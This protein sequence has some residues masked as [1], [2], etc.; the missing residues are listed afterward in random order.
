MT[1]YESAVAM[2]DFDQRPKNMLGIRKNIRKAPYT[3][4]SLL[5]MTCVEQNQ[6][7]KQREYSL[8][9]TDPKD[10]IYGLLG[11]ASDYDVLK[12][13]AERDAQRVIPNYAL[14]CAEIYTNFTMTMMIMGYPN[15][16]SLCQFPKT[17]SGLPSWVPDWSTPLKLQLQASMNIQ[18]PALSPLYFAC[19]AGTSSAARMQFF[20][21]DK[22]E[23]VCSTDGLILDKIAATRTTYSEITEKSKDAVAWVREW[24]QV[25]NNLSKQRLGAYEDDDERMLAVFR[26]TTADFCVDEEGRWARVSEKGLAAAS[27]VHWIG[28]DEEE[29][30]KSGFLKM[31]EQ[32]GL[33]P[34]VD[35]EAFGDVGGFR[36]IGDVG[37]RCRGRRPFVTEKGYLGLGP[38]AVNEGDKVGIFA[39]LQ[40]PFLLRPYG[41][42]YQLV[43]E[44]YVDGVTD[45]EAFEGEAVAEQILLY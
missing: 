34:R 39:G 14:S 5:R 22:K 9:A 23:T 38:M 36:Y 2:A 35:H 21:T 26:T 1:E 7:M 44:A 17:I 4:M 29:V 32:N 31:L 28:A 33:P 41:S 16:I 37:L 20:W 25:L 30:K 13:I 10:K 18:E 43:G 6:S 40:V 8:Q 3:L 11:I 19:G 42:M 24:I 15:I 12:R 45:G 27:M